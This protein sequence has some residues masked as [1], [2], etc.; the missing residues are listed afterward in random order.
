[1]WATRSAP[2]KGVGRALHPVPVLTAIV[3]AA[4]LLQL[5]ILLKVP[6]WVVMTDE[7]L[8]TKLALAVGNNVSPTARIHG[9]S[10]GLLSQL[11]TVLLAPIVTLWDMPTAIKVAHV[12]N[13]LL[14]ASTAIPAYLLARSAALPRAAAYGVAA[15]SVFTPWLVV[16]TVIWPDAVA[17]P[18]FV[19]AIVA[20]MRAMVAPSARNDVLALGG[21]AVAFFARTQFALLAIVFP[22]VLVVH[23]LASRWRSARA[24]GRRYGPCARSC[25]SIVCCWAPTRSPALPRS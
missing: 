24:R 8:Y 4:F 18:A 12:L 22:M 25:A 6:D 5:P 14:L 21:L 20:M 19:W 10:Y 3:L 9:E 11:Y 2:V 15:L 16:G 13:G 7:L 17:Y 1:M 23:R